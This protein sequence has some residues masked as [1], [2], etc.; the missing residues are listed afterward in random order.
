MNTQEPISPRSEINA[1]LARTIDQRL[2]RTMFQPIVNMRSGQVGGYEVLTRPLP[3]SGF[4]NAEEMF[5]AA[6][7]NPLNWDLEC[8]SRQL[9]IEAA[10]HWKPGT[11]LFMN[12]SPEVISNRLFTR[13]L[14]KELQSQQS[15]GPT[16]IVIEVTERCKDHEF[17]GL[18][19]SIETLR[20]SGF[21]IAID[22]VGAGTSGLNRIMSLRPGWLKLDR[23]LIDHLDEDKVRQHLIRFLVHFGKLSSIKIIGE[24]IERI[25]ELNTLID[26]GVDYAQ[27]YLLARPGEKDQDISED[28][29]AHIRYRAAMVS[30]R[31]V[32]NPDRATARTLKRSAPM[33]DAST[34]VS[35]VASSML[36][37]LRQPGI[38][39]T[40]GPRF[41]GW[42]DRDAIL[43]AASDGRA[44]LPISFLIGSSRTTVDATMGLVEALEHASARDDHS[45]ASPLV[46]AD[47][48]DLIGI[49]TMGDLLQ[50]AAGACRSIQFRHA[51][52]TGLPGRV[53][54]DQHLRD[55]LESP[56]PGL[57]HD[58][59]FVDLRKFS[60][61][62]QTYGYELGDQVIQQLVLEIRTTLLESAADAFVGHLGDDQF[63]VSAPSNRMRHRIEE[64]IQ[65]FERIVPHPLQSEPS[66]RT[67]SHETPGVRLIL[68]E[69][70]VPYCKDVSELYRARTELRAQLYAG[71]GT[72]CGRSSQYIR[73]NA[74]AHMKVLRSLKASA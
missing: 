64:F 19:G 65:Q 17:D 61:F 54:T 26:L 10:S 13:Q 25:E 34:R 27:G 40:D 9:A 68:I 53:R 37:N 38:I 51:P 43:R 14:T 46:V 55:L 59:T 7:M 4:A 47:G 73:A 36:Q 48:E 49:V 32:Q 35:A 62:N 44:S 29:R 58:V 12:C 39:I 71:G 42:C 50:A 28:L 2:V 22:D 8:L 15:L 45:L 56:E 52:L 30:P 67:P 21:H 31:Q 11:L 6:E 74:A 24:G 3:E 5:S 66:D 18:V 33:V 57:E 60:K 69:S 16:R 63:L 70:A 20:G 1:K 23:E 72:S 41:A